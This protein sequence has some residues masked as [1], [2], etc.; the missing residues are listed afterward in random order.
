MK[1]EF[2]IS[3]SRFKHSEFYCSEA[4][5]EWMDIYDEDELR[6]IR[7]LFYEAGSLKNKHI[8]SDLIRS[9]QENNQFPPW[10]Q[11]MGTK[12][13]LVCEFKHLGK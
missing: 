9:M 12:D 5:A 1:Y 8:L 7:S 2:S 10:I 3:N 13:N 6:P 4:D 11:A